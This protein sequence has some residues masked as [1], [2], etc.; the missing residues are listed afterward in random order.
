MLTDIDHFET[1]DCEDDWEALLLES[2]LIKD[3]RPKYNSMQ[4]DGKTYP[5]IA[6]TIKDE[7]P[8]VFVTRSPGDKEFRGSKL[9]GPFASSGALNNAVHMLQTIYKFRTCSLDIREDD[10][11]NRFFRPCLLHAIDRCSAPCANRISRPDY[12]SEIDQFLKFMQS[13][14]SVML[15][16]LKQQMET[17]SKNKDYEEAARIRDQKDAIDKLSD[18]T[19]HEEA[20]QSEVTIFAS[21]PVDSMR[22]LEKVLHA[23]GAL[24]CIEAFD[25]AHLQGTETVASKVCFIDGRPH[26]EGYRRFKIQTAKNDDYMSMRK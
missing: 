15:R 21:D 18:R 13:K 19:K 4:L 16:D 22:A 2:R 20:W 1:I 3:Y 10:K 23:K 12:R 25:I 8:G 26:K 17:A 9:F 24:R 11:T 14:R 5:Y 6:V 7:F